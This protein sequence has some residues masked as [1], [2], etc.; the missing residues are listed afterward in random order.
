MSTGSSGSDSESPVPYERTSA[1]RGEFETGGRHPHG[2]CDSCTAARIVCQQVKLISARKR[3]T[4]IKT[5][6]Y[7][8]KNAQKCSSACIHQSCTHCLPNFTQVNTLA[9]L[10][11]EENGL[12]SSSD[13]EDTPSKAQSRDR[14]DQSVSTPTRSKSRSRAI[15]KSVQVRT[16]SPCARSILKRSG[17]TVP[18]ERRSSQRLRM[19]STE[20]EPSHGN[21]EDSNADDASGDVHENIEDS[22]AIP[23]RPEELLARWD[24]TMLQFI[25]A[26]SSAMRKNISLVHALMPIWGYAIRLRDLKENTAEATKAL[27]VFALSGVQVAGNVELNKS[28][29]RVREEMR[30]CREETRSQ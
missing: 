18:V 2:P 24:S 12:E 11:A 7:C 27:L 17:S 10:K 4:A 19:S 23:S 1:Y 26:L 16:K 5:C 22:S 25:T 30:Q 9:K 8:R 6:F 29:E 13:D 20:Y 14:R 15:L 28:L 21:A 3:P